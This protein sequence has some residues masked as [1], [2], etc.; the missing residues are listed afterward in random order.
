MA[1]ANTVI[2]AL[3]EQLAQQIVDKTIAQVEAAE[4]RQSIEALMA[5]RGNE[6]VD[7]IEEPREK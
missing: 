1:D 4:L 2:R 3:G 7:V 5:E 6:P